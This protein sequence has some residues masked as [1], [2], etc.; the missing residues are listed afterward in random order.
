MLSILPFSISHYMF[1]FF[2]HA[3]TPVTR[4]Y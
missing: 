1:L 2:L 4:R 3:V